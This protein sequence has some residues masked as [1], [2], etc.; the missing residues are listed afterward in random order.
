MHIFQIYMNFPQ[1]GRTSLHK[2]AENGHLMVV[3]LLLQAG[4]EV[5]LLDEVSLSRVHDFMAHVAF[6]WGVHSSLK[7]FRLG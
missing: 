7:L 6:F 3:N 2:A 5:K 1:E 4:A